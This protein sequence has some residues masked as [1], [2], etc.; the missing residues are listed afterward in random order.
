MNPVLPSQFQASL[1]LCPVP[2]R[3]A[4]CRA[5]GLSIPSQLPG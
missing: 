3:A 1:K 2:V 5:R 4:E